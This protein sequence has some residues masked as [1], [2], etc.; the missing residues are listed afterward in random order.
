MSAR[1]VDDERDTY[2]RM[3]KLELEMIR[4]SL[5]FL[6]LTSW[7]APKSLRQR[8]VLRGGGGAGEGGKVT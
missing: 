8:T 1:F 4:P 6:S 5:F 2:L 7:K 3:V